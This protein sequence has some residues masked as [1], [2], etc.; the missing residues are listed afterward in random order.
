MTAI[1][2][3]G[4]VYNLYNKFCR[5]HEVLNEQGAK[6]IRAQFFQSKTWQI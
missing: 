3:K 1:L 4:I 2:L 6:P 5:R